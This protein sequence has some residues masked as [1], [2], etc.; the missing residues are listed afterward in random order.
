M[1]SWWLLIPA[2]TVAWCKHRIGDWSDYRSGALSS[3]VSVPTSQVAG[4]APA[5]PRPFP[6]RPASESEVVDRILQHVRQIVEP[7]RDLQVATEVRTHGRSRADVLVLADDRLI[8]IEAKLSDWRRALGQ[9]AL[10]QSVADLSYVAM[11]AGRIPAA[12]LEHAEKEGIGVI[13]VSVDHLAL[14]VSAS[15]GRPDQTARRACQ[16]RLHEAVLAQD[17]AQ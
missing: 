7:A 12:L 13:A 8:A 15:A 14:V 11:W 1:I 4:L 5:A 16:V 3:P 10:N 17:G 2:R 6:P 9:A